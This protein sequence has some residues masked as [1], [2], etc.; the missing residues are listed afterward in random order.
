MAV[1]AARDSADTREQ[2]VRQSRH[3]ADHVLEFLV[4]LQFVEV[5]VDGVRDD[6]AKF[7]NVVGCRSV[8][9]R[10]G[11]NEIV[12]VPVEFNRLLELRCG[13]LAEAVDLVLHCHGED[14]SMLEDVHLRLRHDRG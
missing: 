5:V 1:C 11:V 4:E 2:S 6:V 14:S 9:D 13:E 7:F 3:A 8:N 10:D 12:V